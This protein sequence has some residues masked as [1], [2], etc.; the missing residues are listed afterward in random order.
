[1]LPAGDL[2][3]FSSPEGTK[4]LWDDY[5]ARVA[6]A[7]RMKLGR[8]AAAAEEERLT[9]AA[10][11]A[12]LQT[13]AERLGGELKSKVEEVAGLE[14]ERGAAEQKASSCAE[15]LVA[16]QARQQLLR[17]GKDDATKAS[18]RFRSELAKAE[19]NF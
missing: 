9:S 19:A 7:Q 13:E 10:A 18:A 5:L 17:I 16:S 2:F 11:L 1:M 14:G 3:S 8:M 6:Q 12:E 15:H 4:S